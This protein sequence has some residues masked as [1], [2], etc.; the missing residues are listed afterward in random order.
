MVGQD[1][2]QS[3]TALLF[4]WCFWDARG[5]FVQPG[6]VYFH[7]AISLLDWGHRFETGEFKAE[8]WVG[9]VVPLFIANMTLGNMLKDSD[10]GIIVENPPR[11]F[12]SN[13]SWLHRKPGK[14]RWSGNHSYDFSQI[15]PCWLCRKIIWRPYLKKKCLSWTAPRIN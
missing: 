4:F 12:F 3:S 6:N 15:F 10:L 9:G 13:K 8:V 7:G 2:A 1:P 11:D 5:S 14:N